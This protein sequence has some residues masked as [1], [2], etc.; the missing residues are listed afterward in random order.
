MKF[1]NSEYFT[2]EYIKNKAKRIARNTW[3]GPGKFG[4]FILLCVFIV[5][6]FESLGLS[7]RERNLEFRNLSNMVIA[8]E[9]AENTEISYT[10]LNKSTKINNLNSNELN[11]RIKIFAQ[12]DFEDKNLERG[13]MLLTGAVEQYIYENNETENVKY[14]SQEEKIRRIYTQLIRGSGCEE[15]Q[16]EK[17]FNEDF[18]F[19]I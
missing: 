18:F 8:I 7:N 14:L 19:D 16:D 15:T 4:V 9:G 12:K 6:T 17:V 13:K 11:E 3:A 5:A 10:E 2:K 1:I